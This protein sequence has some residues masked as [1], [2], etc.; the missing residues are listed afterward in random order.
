M[1]SFAQ[2][3]MQRYGWSEGKG[4]GRTE[5]GMKNAIKVKLK[6]NTGG[7]GHDQGAEFSFHWWD[8][9]FNKAASSFKVNESEDGV[10]LEKCEGKKITP[11]LISN[12]RGLPTRLANKSLLY[13][14]FV[15]AGTYDAS[16]VDI[17]AS[18]VDTI[19]EC[20]S[21]DGGST[22]SEDD[23]ADLEGNK[24]EP[25]NDT[26]QKMFLK[27]GLTG[28]KAARHGHNLNGKLQRLMQQ[29]ERELPKLPSCTEPTKKAELEVETQEVKETVDKNSE[30]TGNEL[31]CN[32]KKKKK[33]KKKVDN[34]IP[35]DLDKMSSDNTESEVRTTKKKKIDNSIP[36]DLDELSP[37]DT[38]PEVRT[39]K[40]KKEKK[41]INDEVM[42][43]ACPENVVTAG[44]DV[45][46]KVKKRKQNLEVENAGVVTE[47]PKKK[48]KKKRT[49]EGKDVA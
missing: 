48:K 22:D 16:K 40:K 44:S 21:S 15:K 23:D 31:E 26:L 17:N 43:T 38:E 42:G 3:E 35:I 1:P 11:L 10:Q 18:K 12:K 47:Q 45:P 14:T 46:V 24:K 39:K 8:H 37:N 49:H 5:N 41:P 7:L 29:E 36:I 20:S 9:I 25:I 27:T 13:G 32:T 28:H 33:K 19:G 2:K 6:N 34:S 4:L 30:G